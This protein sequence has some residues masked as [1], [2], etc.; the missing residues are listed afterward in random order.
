MR[1]EKRSLSVKVVACVRID[2]CVVKIAKNMLIVARIGTVAIDK[3]CNP[4]YAGRSTSQTDQLPVVRRTTNM[5]NPYIFSYTFQDTN[6][7]KAPIAYYYVPTTPGTVTVAQVIADYVGLGSVLD[8][9]SNAEI[10]AGSISLPQI[11]DATWKGVP[12]AENDV[13]DVINI[14][15]GNAVTTYRW[16][17]L[18]PNLKEAELDNGRVDM[19]NA[20][21]AALTGFVQAGATHGSFTNTAGQDL[22]TVKDAFQADR[23][24]R[25]QLRSRSLAVVAG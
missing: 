11:P 6:G 4:T 21:I 8:D 18:I 23:K 9:A 2:L 25:R 24:H 13:S 1:N 10:I 16:S 22:T 12:V 14:N 3:V 19:L 20:D 15:Y 17:G 7:V 5:A